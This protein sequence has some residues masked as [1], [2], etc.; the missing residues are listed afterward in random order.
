[1]QN[2]IKQVY[3]IFQFNKVNFI[4]LTHYYSIDSLPWVYIQE[5]IYH[6]RSSTRNPA[7][8]VNAL[9]KHIEDMVFLYIS[10]IY[11]TITIYL[12]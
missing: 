7:I 8:R 3:I 5:R 11:L 1:M 4:I 6:L 10:T 9:A 2:V 12:Q